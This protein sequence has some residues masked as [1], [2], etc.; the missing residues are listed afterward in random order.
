MSYKGFCRTWG[1]R[2]SYK[3][4]KNVFKAQKIDAGIVSLYLLFLDVF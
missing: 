4:L 2:C 3:T 1:V